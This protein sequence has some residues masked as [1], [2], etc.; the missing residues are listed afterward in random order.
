MMRLT[1]PNCDAQYEVDDAVIPPEGRDV[2]CSNC[3]QTWFV[4]GA[5]RPPQ[6][7]TAPLP[8]D[9]DMNAPEPETAQPEPQPAP[10]RRQLDPAIAG[11][12]R[13]EAE[14]EQRVRAAV[15]PPEPDESGFGPEAVTQQDRVARL[16][17]MS[18]DSGETAAADGQSGSRRDM[19]PDIDDINATLDPAAGREPA[20]STAPAPEHE[21]RSKGFRRGFALVL[22]LTALAMGAYT[23]AP[24]IGRLHPALGDAMDGYAGMIDGW[25]IWANTTIPQ[26]LQGLTDKLNAISG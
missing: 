25:R 17:G 26:V 3:G 24:A 11:V 1:C 21:A 15:A 14:R 4:R 13:E 22:V 20:A 19:L 7:E 5:E 8:D 9:D 23:Y 2:Q 16:R 6:A 10:Q 12:L 18:P